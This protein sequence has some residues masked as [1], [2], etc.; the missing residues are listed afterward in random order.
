MQPDNELSEC[1]TIITDGVRLEI[2]TV[3]IGPAE[4]VLHV[5][6]IYGVRSTWTQF[7]ESADAALEAGYQAI[8]AEGVEPFMDMEGFEYLNEGKDD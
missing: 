6:N 5:E 1:K 2:I 3:Q 8:L 4:W 7:F